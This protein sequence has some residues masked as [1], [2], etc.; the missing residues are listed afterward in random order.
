MRFLVWI[1]ALVF[2]AP[3]LFAQQI[4]WRASH[5][6]ALKEA[7]ESGKPVL[8]AVNMDNERANDKI[9][10]D[11]YKDA[12]IV[13]LT[14]EF[15][16]LI[17]SAGFHSDDDDSECPRCGKITCSDH[18]RTD[19]WMRETFYEGRRKIDAPQHIF[20]KP[21]GTLFRTK[22]FYLTKK[23]LAVVLKDVLRDLGRPVPGEKPPEPGT[24]P[25]ATGKKPETVV[26][27]KDALRREKDEAKLKEYARV[28][29]KSEDADARPVLEELLADEKLGDKRGK[30]LLGLGF[31]GNAEAV[32]L[33]V[34]VLKSKS[35]ELRRH[36]AVALEDIGDKEALSA[37]RK[38]LKS[39]KEEEVRCNLVRAMAACGVKDK[40]VASDLIKLTRDKSTKVQRNALVGLGLFPKN[41]KVEKTLMQV[42]F[43]TGRNAMRNRRQARAA[44]YALAQIRSKKAL[45]EARKRLE[46]ATNEFMIPIFEE[47]VSSLESD[48]DATA[49]KRVEARRAA[50]GESIPRDRDPAGAGS[51]EREGGGRPRRPRRE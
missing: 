28:L 37:V 19:V 47:I 40:R 20:L 3:G 32:G 4:D 14:K 13:A 43:Q 26:E 16:C 7:K 46:K 33:L 48:F 10:R 25:V 11:H 5:V 22:T 51:G 21:D 2:S 8:I 38:V 27:L 42:A 12:G 29:Y 23:E 34:E 24:K 18:R 41:S 30:M 15:V 36:A 17:A 49:A 39:E 50:A 1:V 31:A 9:A 35:P 45:A 44:Y 6:E